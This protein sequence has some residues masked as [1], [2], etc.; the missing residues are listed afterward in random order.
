MLNV[1]V[2]LSK[3]IAAGCIVAGLKLLIII[4]YI[5]NII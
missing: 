4:F 5:F 2:T 1:L 3:T